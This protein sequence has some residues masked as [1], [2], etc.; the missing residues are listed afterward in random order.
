MNT[1]PEKDL[2][3]ALVKEPVKGTYQHY[4]GA[5]HE[6]L[7]MAESP[8]TGKRYVVYQ[9]VGLTEILVGPDP[10]N[11][12]FPDSRFTSTPTKGELAVCSV[13]RFTE[14]VDGKEYHPGKR[15]PRFRL[16]A[17]APCR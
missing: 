14:L 1:T 2:G 10:E 4:K 8:E 12:F 7:G 6:V 13:E 17:P 16:V 3:K 9:A 11:N 15:V 5:F